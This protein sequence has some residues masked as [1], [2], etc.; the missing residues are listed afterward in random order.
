MIY[1]PKIRRARFKV[2]PF[3]PEQMEAI[4][5]AMVDTISQRI[6]TGMNAS[7]SPAKPLKP[8]RNGKRGYPDYKLARGRAPIRDWVMRGLTMRS[9][10]VKSAN[11]NRV[12]IGFV[13]PQADYI[14]HV[15]NKIERMFGVSGNDRKVLTEVV[16]ATARQGGGI[17]RVVRGA[18]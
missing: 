17:V 2:G 3:S 7:D 11:E 10:K 13:N 6:R 1:Q 14:A 15:N 8:G 4:G 18:A 5:N 16:S 9:L 12:V